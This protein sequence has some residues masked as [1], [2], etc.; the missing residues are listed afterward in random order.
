MI[1]RI[2]VPIEETDIDVRTFNVLKRAGFNTV[3][4]II[5]MTDEELLEIRNLG[6]KSLAD[7][8]RK[9][10]GE[11]GGHESRKNKKMLREAESSSKNEKRTYTA[12]ENKRY[13]ALL[14]EKGGKLWRRFR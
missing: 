13:K 3:G 9:I 7:I 11:E 2:N 4:E 14:A 1:S 8:K 10:F 5:A 6:V 12:E